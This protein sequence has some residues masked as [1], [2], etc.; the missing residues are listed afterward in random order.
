MS[1]EVVGFCDGVKGADVFGWAW[2]PDYPDYPVEI[3][4][5]VDGALAGETVAMLYRADLRAAGVGHGKYGWRLPLNLREQSEAVQ[6]V[7]RVKD[8][9]PL[10]QGGFEYSARPPVEDL[11]NPEFQAFVASVL[12]QSSKTRPEEDAKSR[13]PVN[14]LLFCP[15]SPDATSMGRSEYSY[16]FVMKA[17][18][19]LLEQLG[20]VHVVT[21]P[22]TEADPL[23]TEHIARGETSLLLSFTPPHR[24]VMGL[25]CPSIP[26]VAWEFPTIPTSVWENDLRH[27]WRFVL[28]QTGRVIT[29]S[30]LA[31]DAV[32][33]AMGDQFP[34]I[35]LPAPV[36]DRFPELH[37]VGAPAPRAE[38]AIDG[39][40]Y[41][42]RGRTFPPGAA[43]PPMPAAPD[44]D[45]GPTPA[46]TATLEGAV[47]TSVFS[48]RD[49]RKNWLDML[50]AFVTAHRD[51]PEAT[52][53]L[54]MIGPD[55][56]LWW[57][58]LHDALAKL[59]PFTCRVL[60]AQGYM[61]EAQ[62]NALIVAS[63]WVVNASQAE[64]LCLPLLE[65]M[66]AGRPAVAPAH[67]AMSDYIDSSNAVIVPSD[68][69]YCGWPHDRRE[70]LT[71]TRHRVSWPGLVAAFA[72]A[73][74]LTVSEPALYATL[75]KAARSTA[76]AFCE[77]DLV[78]ARLDAF[79]G[80]GL[81]LGQRTAIPS[82]VLTVAAA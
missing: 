37:A 78:A 45:E 74:R 69:E 26:V 82:A 34:V 76:K 64:G 61:D 65:F 53:V 66:C 4:L 52:L 19:P 10:G 43:S 35:A 42:T 44:A 5:W 15:S 1:G 18:K 33:A 32:Q 46:S 79:L 55:A 8:G 23:Y 3:E 22:A 27:D 67:T 17:F 62:Y 47:F 70:E 56:G 31:A 51:N 59:P 13:A 25:R 29:L 39:W 41:D 48:P 30:Q 11:E 73:Y 60:V 9:E 14:F 20:R 7:V 63:H 50:G 40:F 16:A 80:L 36:W 58:E 81:E 77:D 57:W 72:E 6:V 38:I 12:S 2:R 71:T 68:E 28:R 49:G 75:S 24:T 54:K 21:N